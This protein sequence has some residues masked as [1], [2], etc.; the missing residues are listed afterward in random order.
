MSERQLRLYGIP[1]S[2]PVRATRGVL[3]HNRLPYRYVELL[4][5]THP[6]SLWAL[7]FRGATVP[8]V[9]LPDGRRVQGSLAI[10][11]ALEQ[12][13][14]SPPLYPRELR[15]ATLS[16]TPSGGGKRFCSRSRD[17]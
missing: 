3:E 15:L 5:G 17:G 14:P 11:R 13:A 9:R 16:R 6:P 8:A 12:I 2:H 7:G 4:A 1:M 10:A